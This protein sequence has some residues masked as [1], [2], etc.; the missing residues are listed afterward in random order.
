MCGAPTPTDLR[1]HW[2]FAAL[3]TALLPAVAFAKLSMSVYPTTL[4]I[5]ADADRSVSHFIYVQNGG[6]VPFGLTH[7]LLDWRVTDDGRRLEL[8]P[9]GGLNSLVRW[10]TVTPETVN[11]PPGGQAAFRLTVQ[12]PNA[13]APGAYG[14]LDVTMTGPVGVAPGTEAAVGGTIAVQLFIRAK[15]AAPRVEVKIRELRPPT[16]AEN[17]RVRLWIKN[18]GPVHVRA[19]PSVD[20]LGPFGDFVAYLLPDPLSI[21][22]LP[23]QSREVVLEWRGELAPSNYEAIASVNAGGEQVAIDETSFDLENTPTVN[24]PPTKA[25]PQK[26]RP[27]AKKGKGRRAP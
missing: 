21:V 11:V 10:V 7:R 2:A 12:A 14:A 1:R 4:E 25:P 18:R 8:P 20:L 6:E 17:L 22:L 13:A 23:N 16:A 24:L 15:N 9:E 26:A 3:V 5:D 27:A 19:E